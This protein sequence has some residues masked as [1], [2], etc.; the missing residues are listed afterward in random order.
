[1][2]EMSARE[3]LIRLREIRKC[4]AC[5]DDCDAIDAAASI[6]CKYE[7]G[8]LVEVS[9]V[10]EFLES[11]LSDTYYC[12]RVWNAWNVGT[13]SENDFELVDVDEIIS[14]LMDA[15]MGNHV[16]GKDDNNAE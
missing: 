14:A 12:T 10:R 6:V 5:T 13:M 11:Q 4:M 16:T 1:M 9:K 8:E 3:T 15:D 7:T 2:N